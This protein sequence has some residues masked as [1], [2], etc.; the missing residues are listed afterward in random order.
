MVAGVGSALPAA[1]TAWAANC[2]GPALSLGRLTSPAAQS[3]GFLFRVQAKPAPPSLLLSTTW[4]P[5]VAV[6]GQSGVMSS[7]GVRVMNVFGTVVS[8]LMVVVAGV[9]S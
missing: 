5:R 3:S 1:S 8:T 4:A 9:W 7:C 6:T 2:W